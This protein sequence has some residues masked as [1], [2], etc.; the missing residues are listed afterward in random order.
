LNI[1]LL[2]HIKAK[3]FYILFLSILAACHSN[4]E[5]QVH[6][7]FY[8]WKSTIE[9]GVMNAPLERLGI[10]RVYLRVFDVDWDASYGGP[11]P[12]GQLSNPEAIPD[13]I[14]I[15][16]TIFIT[17]R[18]FSKL[19]ESQIP[20]L[21]AQVHQKLENIFSPKGPI[22]EVQFDCDWTQ[23][24]REAFFQFLKTFKKQTGLKLSV[25]IR[26]HQIRYPEQ[27]GIPPADR[28]ML[29]FYN[30]GALESWE[31][32]N[33]I[34]N[35]EKASPYMQNKKAYPLPLDLALPIFSWGVIF[36]N[37]KMIRLIHKLS[38]KELRDST[39]FERLDNN[40]Y[41]VINSTYVD[42]LFL[43]ADD[44]IRLEKIEPAKLEEAVKL[45]LSLFRQKNFTL[46][47]Y[48]LDTTFINMLT[49]DHID[50]I[51]E[52]FR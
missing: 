52:S 50:T 36:R 3:F 26:L 8:H 27:T 38:E 17:N 32:T 51:F 2:Q 11:V 49:Y 39:R 7:A 28:G 29:M 12:V 6:R 19:A 25:T 31:E 45:N 15:I 20:A 24:T 13:Q 37:D 9:A 35:L 10:E 21:S 41:R 42:G 4:P 46:S 40:R 1:N 23:T 18:T 5:P 30:M 48:H 43:Y 47:L 33:S 44:S 34:L 16:P 22:Q 14:N